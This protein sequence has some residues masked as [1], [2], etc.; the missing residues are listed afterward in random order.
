MAIDA[1]LI[2]APEELYRKRVTFFDPKKCGRTVGEI[3]GVF[4]DNTG[5]H[6]CIAT[7]DGERHER[8][9]LWPRV[10]IIERDNS[11]G[12]IRIGI[13]RGEVIVIHPAVA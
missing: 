12:D 6:L 3:V 5:L 13:N 8:E 2:G 9:I 4:E 11:S 7:E 1:S 10:G